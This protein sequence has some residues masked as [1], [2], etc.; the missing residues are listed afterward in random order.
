MSTPHPYISIGLPV[1]NGENYLEEA[2]QSLLAQTFTDFELII[3]DNASTDR[4]PAICEAYAARDRRIRYYRNPTNVGAGPN[5]NRTVAL[6]RGVYFKWAAHDDLLTPDYLEKCVAILDQDPTIV[7]CHSY[8]KEI[9]GVGELITI[10]GAEL[11]HA[12]STKRHARFADLI[13]IEHPCYDVFGLLRIDVLRKTPLI[14][15]Y[16]GS[17]RVLLAELAL[18]GRFHQI[19]ETLFIARSH[20]QQSVLALP[21]HRRKHWF[22]TTQ[23]DGR[24]F[25]HWRYWQ[26]YYHALRRTPLSA[27]EK[28][29]CYRQL[30]RYPG[31]AGAALT[32]DLITAINPYYV[33][34]MKQKNPRWLCR[35]RQAERALH[36]LL[37]QPYYKQAR[38]QR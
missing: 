17:D 1:F 7:L 26:E 14:A 10:H 19:P 12:N 37:H 20:P 3:S 38:N 22:D 18:H 28:Y 11:P 25:P 29:A 2:L 24:A 36:T 34:A 8:T 16:I 23:R 15:S 31:W 30:A 6:A 35:V 32:K 4:T 21:L 5:F 33:E 9:S 13:L 27:P